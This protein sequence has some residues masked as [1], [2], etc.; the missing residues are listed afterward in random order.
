MRLGYDAVRAIAFGTEYIIE[1]NDNIIFSRFSDSERQALTYGHDKSWSTA[2]V[3]LEFITDSQSLDI[4][5]SVKESNPEGRNFYSFD[6]YNNDVMIGQIKNFE[7]SPRYP[8][9]KYPLCDR[10]ERFRLSDKTNHVCIYF[11]WSVQGIING[12]EIDDGAEITPVIKSKKVI[13]YGDSIT[14]GYDSESPSRSYASQLADYLDADVINKG[15]GGSVFMPELTN[16]KSDY[17]P[18]LITVAYGTND[19]N[20]CGYDDFEKRCRSFFNN[21]ITNYP[22]TNILAIAPIWRADSDEERSFGKFSKVAETLKNISALNKSI[23]F[24]NGIDFIP[25]DKKYY[26]DSYLHPNDMGFDFYINS[27]INEL[28]TKDII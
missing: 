17:A 24:I 28:K 11:P 12:I 22:D 25:K 20:I 1:E 3:R 15:I 2:G 23:S 21:L 26:R 7:E 10:H 8:Y 14:Q 19:W 18:S 4:S 13:M 6:V 9:K 27:L 5:V 16:I